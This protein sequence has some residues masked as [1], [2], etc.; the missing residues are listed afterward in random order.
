[1]GEDRRPRVA[2]SA[3]VGPEVTIGP[4][5][6]V[7]PGAVVL[8]RTRVGA[9]CIIGANAVVGTPGFG[10]EWRDGGHRRLEHD[11]EVVIED[12]VEIGAGATVAMAKTGRQTRIG[13]GTK[14]DCQVHVGHNV[15]I[16]EHC[17]FVAQAGIA[18][19]SRLGKRV[20][21]AGQT[22]VSDHLT[23]GDNAV[24]YAKS[25]VFRSIPAG[26]QYSGIP[27]RPHPAT[28]RFWAGLWRRF[29]R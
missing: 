13:R 19:S 8:G 29:G 1:M 5:T 17:L 2:P 25:A 22:G 6:V 15:V 14:I 23:I 9:R 27:A 7:M 28:K 26:A 4:D 24:V 16:G 12:D 3:H 21:I 20:T 18:G 11:G 10:Y